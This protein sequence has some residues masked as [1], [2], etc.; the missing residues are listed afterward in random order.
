MPDFFVSLE[1]AISQLAKAKDLA[2]P[3]PSA[4][5]HS[6]ELVPNLVTVDGQEILFHANVG[7]QTEILELATQAR[8]L[9]RVGADPDQPTGR[10]VLLRDWSAA[11]KAGAPALHDALTPLE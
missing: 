9:N 10:Q 8:L 3:P 5:E 7:S 4:T 6:N 11:P 2:A 1:R